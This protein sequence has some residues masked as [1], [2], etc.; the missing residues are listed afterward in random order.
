V[1]AG[2]IGLGLVTVIAAVVR[3]VRRYKRRK[4][5]RNKSAYT[6]LEMSVAPDPLPA[7]ESTEI[8]LSHNWGDD[9]LGRDNHD[10]VVQ[11]NGLLVAA[12]Y[13]TWC[14]SEQ[15]IGDIVD[16]MV[17]GIDNTKVVIVFITKRY[18]E[19]LMT[20][21][22]VQDNCKKEFKYAVRRHTE[23][24]MVPVIMEPGMKDTSKWSG[25]LAMELG[26]TLW[27]DLSDASV[28]STTD[29]FGRLCDEINGRIPGRAVGRRA[30]LFATMGPSLPPSV[31]SAD[32]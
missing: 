24:K 2:A 22:H 25:P 8:F 4:R 7:P 3:G 5:R 21:A 20:P 27:V 14:D 30:S 28:D 6:Q 10:R 13:A 18:M 32:F 9:E 16:R 31:S 12:G 26:G 1:I 17:E 19:K 29:G 15:M 23:A 11:I